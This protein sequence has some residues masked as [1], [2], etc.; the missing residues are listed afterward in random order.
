LGHAAD[1]S[2][3]RERSIVVADKVDR[4]ALAGEDHLAVA[5]FPGAGLRFSH[6]RKIGL[7]TGAKLE[8]HIA[9]RS[10][11]GSFKAAA[12]ATGDAAEAK[13]H[14][15]RKQS[16]TEVLFHD[17][18][19]FAIGT[20]REPASPK[21]SRHR[22]CLP[23]GLVVPERHNGHAESQNGLLPKVYLLVGLA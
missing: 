14:E 9:G 23:G 20:N 12:A 6:D 13:P 11:V 8:D 21:E 3:T 7:S 1:K 19:S 15:D 16:Q 5:R 18:C 17:G 2:R 10:A 4:V 22:R